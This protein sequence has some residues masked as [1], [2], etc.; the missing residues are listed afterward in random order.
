MVLQ[1]NQMD[2]QLQAWQDTEFFV[3]N[4]LLELQ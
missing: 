2:S 3:K 4:F 1:K